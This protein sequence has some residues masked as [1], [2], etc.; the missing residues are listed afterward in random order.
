MSRPEANPKGH[1]TTPA[2]ID[3]PPENVAPVVIPP[4]PAGIFDEPSIR[5]WEE[6]WRAGHGVYKANTDRYI[7]ERYVTLQQRRRELQ[8]II[9]AEGWTSI[10]SQGQTV[11]H[12][13]ARLLGDIES[14]LTPLED[15]LG[16]SPESRIRLGIAAT[17]Q[18]SKLDA[19][20]KGQ[21]QQGD[22]SE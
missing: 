4:A 20:L 22:S 2:T 15:R 10:G 3:A 21:R 18:Q 19:F 9:D 16:L 7:I 11:M 1:A 6:V 8:A 17:E 14:K 13:A 5:L 12:P